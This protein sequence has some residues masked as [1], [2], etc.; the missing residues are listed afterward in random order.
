VVRAEDGSVRIWLL[1]SLVSAIAWSTGA[2]AGRASGVPGLPTKPLIAAGSSVV[3]APGPPPTPAQCARSWNLHAPRATLRWLAEVRPYGTNIFAGKFFTRIKSGTA[4]WRYFAGPTCQFNIWLPHGIEVDATGVW[5]RGEVTGWFGD[6]HRID[7]TVPGDNE[8][9]SVTANGTIHLFALT[10]RQVP[11]TIPGLPDPP[12]TSDPAFAPDPS[13]APSKAQCVGAWNR[14]APRD[15]RQWLAG[16]N[17]YGA[18]VYT[19][20]DS[21]QNVMGRICIVDVYF[22][23]KQYA[24][25]TGVW[26]NGD[27][28]AWDGRLGA[29]RP[30]SPNATVA[31]DGGLRL[32]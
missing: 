7:P 11:A 25:I 15:M 26:K 17:P 1:L 9:A 10:P 3:P 5:K 27:V 4:P 13:S 29:N 16:L 30:I 12:D 28:T 21:A 14:H 8:V 6:V 24:E 19:V 23:A 2:A 32:Y 31:A 18:L 22:G 20:E